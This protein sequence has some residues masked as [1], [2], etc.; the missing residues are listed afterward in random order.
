MFLAPGHRRFPSDATGSYACNRFQRRRTP[1]GPAIT[2][3]QGVRSLNSFSKPGPA[4]I[5]PA[6][7]LDMAGNPLTGPTVRG[8]TFHP[9]QAGPAG[10]PRPTCSHRSAHSDRR[11]AK[12]R[13]AVRSVPEKE[14]KESTA[15]DRTPFVS[16]GS[17]CNMLNTDCSSGFA[18]VRPCTG[19]RIGVRRAIS[20]PTSTTAPSGSFTL[21]K[22]G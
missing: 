16:G 15:Q 5:R 8:F 3:L 7:W 6:V 22:D 21:W 4:C 9:R 10:P 19:R 2:K 14:R 17:T 1:C 13:R 20:M 11:S 18:A 12:Y